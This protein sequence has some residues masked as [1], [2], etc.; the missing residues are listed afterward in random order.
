MFGEHSVV[1]EKPA[2]AVPVF[3]KGTTV[4]IN[5]SENLILNTDYNMTEPEKKYLNVCIDLIIKRL[6]VDLNFGVN[7]SSNI[8][9]G[10]GMGSS[11]SLS[12]ALIRAISKYNNYENNCIIIFSHF[13]NGVKQNICYIRVFIINLIINS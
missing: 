3:S 8:P 10:V 11:A 6:N 5:E 13:R 9:V 4:E 7:V 2:I 1:Y 12:V